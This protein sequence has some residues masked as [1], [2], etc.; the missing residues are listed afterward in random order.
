MAIFILLISVSPGLNQGFFTLIFQGTPTFSISPQ[1]QTIE[2]GNS[3]NVNIRV[4]NVP[5]IYGYQF[6]LLYNDSRLNFQSITF[7][8]TVLGSRTAGEQYCNSS[9]QW[10]MGTGSIGKISCTRNIPNGVTGNGVLATIRFYADTPGTSALS[11][12]NVIV[13][14]PNSQRISVT[15]IGGSVSTEICYDNDGDGYGFPA[16]AI[17]SFSSADCDD[18]PITGVGINPGA[19]EVCDGIDNNCDNI[20]DPGC[21]CIDGTTDICGTDAGLC[22]AGY[23][24]CED[25]DWGTECIGEIPPLTEICDGLDNDCDASTDE[26]LTAP[27]CSRQ[28]GVCAG[29]IRTCGGTSGWLTCTATN[30]GASYVA[31]E[32]NLYC[33]NLDNDCDGSVDE[34]CECITG[35]SQACGVTDVG[36]CAMGTRTCIQGSWGSCSA[37]L[38]S[39]EICDG[40]D[41]DCDASIDEGLIAPSCSLIQGVC[42]GATRTCGG[43][44]GWLTCTATNYGA[45][46]VA[47]ETT[48]YCD[49]LDN[50]CDG[51]TDEGCSCV[52]GTRQACGSDVGVCEQGERICVSGQWSNCI[53]QILPSTETCDG[54]D[55]DCDGSTDE[56]L[57]P[58]SCPLNQGVCVGASSDRVCQG[59]TGW[60]P[61][62]YGSDYALDETSPAYCD[63]LDNDCDGITDEGCSCVNGT[64]RTCGSDLGEC[65]TGIQTCSSAVW[66]PCEGSVSP[67]DEIC[68]NLDNDCDE[69][70]DN[71]VTRICGTDVGACIAGTETCN[72]GLWGEC[73]GSIEPTTE[74][75]LDGID[76]DCAD[77]DLACAICPDGEI[78]SRCDCGG[79]AYVDGFC[80]SAVHRI[81]CG[82]DA[83]CDDGNPA[84]I[85]TCLN[86]SSCAALCE[87]VAAIC[88]DDDGACPSGCTSGE[89][90]DCAANCGNGS[91]DSGEDCSTCPG[92]VT[93]GVLE[94]C[95]TGTCISPAC[96][97]AGSC[98]DSSDCTID[99]C[100]NQGLPAAYCQHTPIPGCRPPEQYSGSPGGGGE[101]DP[102]DEDGDGVPKDRD[103]NDKE[104]A[105]KVCNKGTHCV[106]GR[107]IAT[108]K[109]DEEMLRQLDS[110]GDGLSDW[111][112]LQA[113]TDLYLADTD[114]DLVN[115]YDEVEEGTDPLD[116]QSNNWR[117]DYSSTVKIGDDQH[118]VLFNEKSGKTVPF[119]AK[120]IYASGKKQEMESDEKGELAFQV[121]ETGQILINVHVGKYTLEKTFRGRKESE[122]VFVLPNQAIII[123]DEDLVRQNM[124]FVLLFIMAY[125]L[126][127]VL[128]FIETSYFIPAVTDMKNMP[129]RI[130]RFGGRI[131]FS[132]LFG[133]IPALLY[134]FMGSIASVSVLIIQIAILL[135][136][137]FLGSN[138]RTWMRALLK[139]GVSK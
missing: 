90:P 10:V 89:D 37:I 124:L 42:A 111:D 39:T 76:Q 26:G 74:I 28:Q 35:I 46:Y 17:C 58:P 67:I 108:D 11:F 78:S 79:T 13:G 85:D 62:D 104:K 110:D 53:G 36:Q 84:T 128:A 75:C 48:A 9:S 30:Y 61:C 135:V 116:A 65:S 139:K 47:I 82:D 126:I 64:T 119:R 91:V 60:S 57:T 77:G 125:I 27:F 22:Q 12:L 100:F 93:C 14:D 123:L 24:L 33:D 6:D 96:F 66:G 7:S 127:T 106:G 87:N 94:V 112:E 8:D 56:S 114:G 31:V 117:I 25:G 103:C 40:L 44:Q 21:N 69:T 107:C 137:G 134:V 129:L 113:G 95:S 120:V 43:S 81:P 92:D 118:I 59:T 19:T 63:N 83:A 55:N 133:A 29:S 80:C 41:N 86:P 130:L 101:K 138:L 4:D 51:I 23:Y 102:N 54:L 1:T 72:A 98:A 32:T 122:T 15:V 18:T 45:S 105:I 97:S 50:D 88:G 34:E 131:V 70:I 121:R 73:S 3:F 132:I 5:N 52:N 99:E 49:N 115:D 71:E 20:T 136:L 68:D 109:L 38:P 16:S 2:V